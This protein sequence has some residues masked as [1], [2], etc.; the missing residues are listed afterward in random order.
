MKNRHISKLTSFIEDMIISLHYR[1]AL[2][3]STHVCWIID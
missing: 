1:D 2:A 3:I